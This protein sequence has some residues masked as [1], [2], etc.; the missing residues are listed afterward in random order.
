MS[1]LSGS[2]GSMGAASL[3]YYIFSF[4][5]DIKVLLDLIV[6]PTFKINKP[7]FSLQRFCETNEPKFYPITN[8][9]K[10]NAQH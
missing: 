6:T 1:R 7:K 8:L 5:C 10:M 3:K 2:L 9:N 4:V